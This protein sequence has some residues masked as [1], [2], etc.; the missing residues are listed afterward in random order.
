MTMS[1]GSRARFSDSS[2]PPGLWLIYREPLPRELRRSK[3]LALL[4]A[5]A[6]VAAA[7]WLT[8]ARWSRGTVLV[9]WL[10]GHL[11]WGA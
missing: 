11:A 6:A 9:I 3:L 7:S 1:Q 2:H 5:C 8:P 4:A 10:A